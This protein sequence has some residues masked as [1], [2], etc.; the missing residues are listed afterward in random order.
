MKKLIAAAFLSGALL[1]TTAC[2]VALPS[3]P[4]AA[5]EEQLSAGTATAP[6]TEEQLPAGTIK[7]LSNYPHLSYL[8]PGEFEND[9]RWDGTFARYDYFVNLTFLN[10]QL[11]VLSNLKLGN[12]HNSGVSTPEQFQVNGILGTEIGVFF[13]GEKLLDGACVGMGTHDQLL[14]NCEVYR[15]IYETQ[16]GGVTHG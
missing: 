15:E 1:T 14:S 5:T 8:V 2:Q 3:T 4:A 13:N 10:S 6:A 9:A 16:F 11:C 7:V 12:G